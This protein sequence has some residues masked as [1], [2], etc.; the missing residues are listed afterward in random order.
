[1]RS[2]VHACWAVPRIA[3]VGAHAPMSVWHSLLLCVNGLRLRSLLVSSS[4][5]HVGGYVPSGLQ[6][7]MQLV[8]LSRWAWLLLHPRSLASS[9]VTCVSMVGLSSYVRFQSQFIRT[10]SHLDHPTPSTRLSPCVPTLSSS[11][12][13][14]RSS[15]S[16]GID[17]SLIAVL[18]VSRA[19]LERFSTVLGI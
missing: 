2:K 8:L 10:F 1:M 16:I 11:S 14:A 13:T 3:I 7:L 19:F 15:P 17:V 18:A 12:R 5:T 9:L 4:P 6:L